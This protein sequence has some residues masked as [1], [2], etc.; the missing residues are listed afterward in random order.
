MMAATHG[1]YAGPVTVTVLIPAYNE[2]V[3]LHA[4]IDS[5]LSQSHRPERIIVVAD[6]CTDSTVAI[7]LEAGVEVI[8][9]VDNALKKAGGLMMSPAQC[10]VITEVMPTWGGPVGATASLAT[11]S[12]RKSRRMRHHASNLPLL[13]PATR[14]RLRGHRVEHISCCSFCLWCSRWTTGFASRFG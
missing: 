10:T 7:A 12:T 11:R 3:S 5:L 9:S 14:H 13:G 6:N 4:T 1:V 2:E 8:E